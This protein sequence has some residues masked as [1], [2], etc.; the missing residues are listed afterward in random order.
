MSSCRICGAEFYGPFCPRCG[1]AQNENAEPPRA[2]V[3]N[4]YEAGSA[5]SPPPSGFEAP[6]IPGFMSSFVMCFC[7]D[8]R[9]CGRASRPEF[10]YSVLWFFSSLFLIALVGVLVGF[11]ASFLSEDT[12]WLSFVLSLTFQIVCPLVAIILF[13][14]LCYAACRR[15][16]DSNRSGWLF[17]GGLLFGV[18]LDFRRLSVSFA[19]SVGQS[20]SFASAVIL[21]YW[22]LFAVV[23]SILLAMPPTPG[24]NKYGPE[25]QKR[26]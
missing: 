18:M 20:A 13:I 25:P 2:S 8:T 3:A 21:G 26:G 11:L 14:S 23:M 12:K 19:L 16:H 4:P 24:P 9:T 5:P 7:K 6:D 15:L 22:L 1:A 10:W 17:G